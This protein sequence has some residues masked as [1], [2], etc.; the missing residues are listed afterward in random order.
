[1]L[2]ENVAANSKYWFQSIIFID[3]ERIILCDL[4]NKFWSTVSLN[5][6]HDKIKIFN[7][8]D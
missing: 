1:M 4:N 5:Y 2:F 6:V 3:N 8:M 7:G